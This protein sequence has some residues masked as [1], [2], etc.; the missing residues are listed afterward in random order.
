MLCMLE[1]IKNNDLIIT[2]NK[3][4]ILDYMNNN[5]KLLNIKIMN[6]KQFIDNYFGYTDKKALYYLVN[7]YNYKYDVAKLYLDNFYFIDTLKDELGM[8]QLINYTFLFK[9]NIQRI[10]IIDEDVDSYILDEIKKYDY[11][12]LNSS[13]NYEIPNVYEFKTIEEEVNNV[14]IKIRQLLDKNV[15][16]NHIKLICDKEYELIIRRYFKLYNIP[17]NIGVKHNIYGLKDV[18][19]F[20]E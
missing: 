17:V 13:S 19:K 3:R 10:V 11:L 16:L 2:E 5:K 8:N 12:I 7:K 14:C 20:L 18:Q 9:D 4:L 1:Q 15:E 6:L